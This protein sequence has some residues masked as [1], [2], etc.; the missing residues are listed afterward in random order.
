MM[1]EAENKID[2]KTFGEV[3]YYLTIR[4]VCTPFSI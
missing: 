3:K 4:F 1:S 2:G